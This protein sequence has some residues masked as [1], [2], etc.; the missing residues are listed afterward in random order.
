MGDV[1]DADVGG[2][3]IRGLGAWDWVMVAGYFVLC[4]GVGFGAT[5]CAPLFMKPHGDGGF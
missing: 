3:E 1:S 5:W 4:L 2:A